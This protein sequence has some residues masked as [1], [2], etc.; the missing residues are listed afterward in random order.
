MSATRLAD[1]ERVNATAPFNQWAGF[2]VEAS[3]PGHCVL[4]LSWRP[5]LGQYAGMLHG[6]AAMLETSCGFA[7]SAEIGPVL[8]TQMSVSCLML[9][10]FLPLDRTANFVVPAAARPTNSSPQ[11][12]NGAPKKPLDKPNPIRAQP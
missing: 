9:Q 8:V 10:I 1:F 12:R 7:A 3:T 2:I 4:G 5:E 11:P 6:V